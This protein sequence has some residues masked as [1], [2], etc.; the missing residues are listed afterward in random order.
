MTREE[1]REGLVARAWPGQTPY[2]IDGRNWTLRTE[3]HDQGR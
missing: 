1:Q 2:E 3:A